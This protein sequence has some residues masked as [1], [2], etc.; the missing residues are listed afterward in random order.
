MIELRM[1]AR[2]ITWS[3]KVL[4]GFGRYPVTTADAARLLARHHVSTSLQDLPGKY[5]AVLLPP[6]FGGRRKLLLATHVPRYG[7]HLVLLH[8]AGHL[9]Q[10][11]ADPGITYDADDWRR[12]T[13]LSAD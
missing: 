7:R 11:T 5:A 10:G 13:E 8:E 2:S 9:Y 3:R 1:L 12:P 4:P 6:A